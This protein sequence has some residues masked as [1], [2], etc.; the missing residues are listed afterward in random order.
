MDKINISHFSDAHIA[1]GEMTITNTIDA[2]IAY[3]N[4]PI[5]NCEESITI[6]LPNPFI[7]EEVS[8][9]L[10]NNIEEMLNNNLVNAI[11]MTSFDIDIFDIDIDQCKQSQKIISHV[12]DELS[13]R[14]C[15][16]NIK[17]WFKSILE[18][19]VN[20][21]D[22][23][24]SSFYNALLEYILKKIFIRGYTGE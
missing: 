17:T 12:A 4:E 1:L 14:L 11:A 19:Y 16:P 7:N 15:S 20:D 24:E 21:K 13:I 8:L 23:K 5:H 9:A 2:F 22:I 18:L 3:C 10:D 6:P